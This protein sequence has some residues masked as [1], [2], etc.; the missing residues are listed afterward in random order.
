MRKLSK[1]LKMTPLDES[2]SDPTKHSIHVFANWVKS[3]Q[4]IGW[5]Y[6]FTAVI[7]ASVLIMYVAYNYG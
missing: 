3:L 1:R 5:F 4:W 6:Q 2:Y 7:I